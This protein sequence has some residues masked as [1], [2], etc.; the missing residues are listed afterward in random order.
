MS[1]DIT[2]AGHSSLAAEYPL[3]GGKADIAQ[4]SRAINLFLSPLDEVAL[5]Q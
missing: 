4:A 1:P 3:F 2:Q 5:M